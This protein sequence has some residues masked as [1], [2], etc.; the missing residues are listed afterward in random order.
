VAQDRE[1]GEEDDVEKGQEA[2]QARD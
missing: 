2:N 1:P